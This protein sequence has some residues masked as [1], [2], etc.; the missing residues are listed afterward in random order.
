MRDPAGQNLLLCHG[1]YRAEVVTVGAG[2]RSLSYAGRPLVAGYPTGSM[3]PDY[4][5]WVLMPWPNRV[6]DGRYEFGGRRHQLPLTE[7][8]RGNALHGLVG[9]VEW[10]VAHHDDARASLRLALVPQTGYPYLLDLAVDY[11]LTDAGLRVALVATNTGEVAAPYGTGHHPYFRFGDSP[12][13]DVTL[14]LPATTY[15]PMDERGL[16]GPAQPVDGTAYDFREGRTI[17]EAVIDHPFGGLTGSDATITGPDGSTITLALHE[18][19]GWLHVFTS[20]THDPPRRSLAVEPT[21]CPPDA[22]RTGVDLVVLEPGETH[23][24]SFTVAGSGPA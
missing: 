11:E 4:R 6:G 22:F 5:G 21:T 9:W 15:C 17:G 14:A 16:A 10:T 3:C 18:G 24:A 20:D 23:R 1:P 2:L 8:E 19:F 7:P 13:E 12:V